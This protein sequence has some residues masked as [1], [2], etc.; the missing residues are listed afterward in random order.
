M[1]VKGR[2]Y[3]MKKFASFAGVVGISLLLAFP[4]L[5][6]FKTEDKVQVSEQTMPSEAEEIEPQVEEMVS[7]PEEITE[8]MIEPPTSQEL[9]TT[10]DESTA[11]EDGSLEEVAAANQSL[12][13][14]LAAIEAAGL[15]QALNEQSS[16]TIFAPSNEAFEALPEG[17]LESLLQPDNQETL[18]RI[19]AYHVIEGKV[20]SSDIEPGPVTTAEGNPVDVQVNGEADSMEVSVNGANVVETD[21][22]AS[23]GVIHVIDKVML[24]PES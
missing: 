17:T 4:A 10:E 3:P 23:N 15:T 24:P 2:I 18:R 7:P 8:P 11:S 1:K 19:L 16:I 12:T 13:T 22:E 21:L 5:A 20:T 6:Q 9:N 14:F